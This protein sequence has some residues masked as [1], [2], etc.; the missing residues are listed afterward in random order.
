MLVYQC[1]SDLHTKFLS[2][3]KRMNPFSWIYVRAKT[4]VY[5]KIEFD[6]CQWLLSFN[7]GSLLGFENLRTAHKQQHPLYTKLQASER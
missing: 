5:E 4:F 2:R 6:R 1:T 7:T 3:I